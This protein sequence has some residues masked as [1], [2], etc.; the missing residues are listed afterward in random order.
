LSTLGL[1]L[2]HQGWRHALKSAMAIGHPWTKQGIGSRGGALVESRG[3]EFCALLSQ[4]RQCPKQ[5]IES[6][7]VK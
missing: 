5:I 7:N 2:L 3:K 6:L 4:L 1:A